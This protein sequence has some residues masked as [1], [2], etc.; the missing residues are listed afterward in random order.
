MSEYD[1]MTIE[2]VEAESERLS[3]LGLECKIGDEELYTRQL[4]IV[5]RINELKPDEEWKVAVFS[6]RTR[7][8]N[9]MRT[10]TQKV[11]W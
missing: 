2:Q 6:S 10:R 9:D 1:N 8:W 11:K 7:F 5:Q 4:Q 3:K